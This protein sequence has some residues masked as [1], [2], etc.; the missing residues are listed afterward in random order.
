MGRA[1]FARRA[2]IVVWLLVIALAGLVIP[3]ASGGGAG[4]AQ[5]AAIRVPILAYHNV[6]YSGSAYSVTPEQLAEQCR[7]L[8]E[9]GYIAITLGE[10]WDAAMGL[11]KLP[12]N[13][14]V[15]TNDDGWSSVMAFAEITAQHGMPA[16]FFINNVS[17]LTP[18]QIAHLAQ[19]GAVEAHTATHAHLASM[20]YEA[21]L[22]EIVQNKAYLEQITGRPVRFLAWPFAERNESAVQA[23]QAAGIVAAFGLGGTPAYVGAIDP[24]HI[25]RILMTV[26][27]DIGTFAAKVSGW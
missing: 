27:D 13:P 16:T 5:G 15:L 19:F 23:A 3:V 6:D 11:A 22:A 24:Y 12:P 1:V 21:Q 25:P 7:W 26:E 18:D 20:E 10:F 4:A 2:R 8:L 14:V 17:P 9:N